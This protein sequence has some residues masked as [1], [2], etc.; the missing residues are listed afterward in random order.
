MNES[1]ESK[2]LTSANSFAC[3]RTSTT[4]PARLHEIAAAIPLNPAP[5]M[6]IL[7]LEASETW[8]L[9]SILDSEDCV[10]TKALLTIA[11]ER[12]SYDEQPASSRMCGSMVVNIKPKRWGVRIVRH[13]YEHSERESPTTD[14]GYPFQGLGKSD[15]TTSALTGFPSQV[16]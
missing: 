11:N 5:T 9:V 7:N 10:V 4:C 12:F 14:C 16:R 6:I 13:L 3:S 1:R 2:K 8:A 15:S